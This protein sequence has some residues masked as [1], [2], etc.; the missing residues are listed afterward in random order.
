MDSKS[1]FSAFKLFTQ[2][3]YG[4][5]NPILVLK[6]DFCIII[7]MTVF[8]SYPGTQDHKKFT[9]SGASQALPYLKCLTQGDI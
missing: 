1:D 6:S 4:L 7:I 3:L 2:L 5:C 8:N 9:Q